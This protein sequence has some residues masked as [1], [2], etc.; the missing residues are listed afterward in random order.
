MNQREKSELSSVQGVEEK[1]GENA[2]LYI[3]PSD[4]PKGDADVFFML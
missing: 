2:Q 1:S 3:R 4:K